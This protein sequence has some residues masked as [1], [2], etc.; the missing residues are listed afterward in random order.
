VVLTYEP[1]AGHLGALV[2]KLFGEEPDQ[3]VAEDLRRFR[4]LMETGTIMTVDGQPSGREPEAK[5]A[6]A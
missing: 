5:S 6:Q 2:A 1:P 3:Q 4:S